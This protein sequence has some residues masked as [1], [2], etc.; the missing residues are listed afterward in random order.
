MSFEQ[1]E[2]LTKST[3]TETTLSDLWERCMSNQLTESDRYLLAQLCY[4]IGERHQI[5][6]LAFTETSY[7]DFSKKQIVK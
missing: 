7:C 4:N 6:V 5:P 1:F 3:R 2:E